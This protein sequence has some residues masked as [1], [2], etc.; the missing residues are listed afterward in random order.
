M[1]PVI[2]TVLRQLAADVERQDGDAAVKTLETLR[3]VAGDQ[4]TDE[5]IR[6][7]IARGLDRLRESL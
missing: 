5:L 1:N 3:V 4:L 2:A 7:L 6:Q